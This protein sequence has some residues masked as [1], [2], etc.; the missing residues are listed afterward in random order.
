MNV[1]PTP[2]EVSPQAFNYRAFN[3]RVKKIPSAAEELHAFALVSSKSKLWKS[4]AGMV[5]RVKN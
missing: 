3:L 2:G 5:L 4:C 1:P